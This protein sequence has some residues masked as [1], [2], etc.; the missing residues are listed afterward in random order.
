MK[1]STNFTH[2]TR[3]V[4]PASFRAKATGT[5][6]SQSMSAASGAARAQCVS[7]S[8]PAKQ[9]AALVPTAGYPAPMM[10]APA[11][12]GGQFVDSEFTEGEN[13]ISDTGY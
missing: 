9:R 3:A 6:Q 10:P 1:T 5:G 4:D 13:L 12:D 7:N 8:M 2:Q 11:L